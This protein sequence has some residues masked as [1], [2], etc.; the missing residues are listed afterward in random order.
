[1]KPYGQVRPHFQVNILGGGGG[2]E[3]NVSLLI[4]Q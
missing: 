3:E 2:G 1:M 4:N